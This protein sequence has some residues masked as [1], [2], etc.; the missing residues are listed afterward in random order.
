MNTRQTALALCR[1]AR[2]V[3]GTININ[4][5]YNIYACKNIDYICLHFVEPKIC[6]CAF[7]SLCSD[8]G[9]TEQ[10]CCQKQTFALFLKMYVFYFL[11]PLSQRS[12]TRALKWSRGEPKTHFP[13][14]PALSRVARGTLEAAC[15]VV[16]W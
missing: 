3:L 2:P 7:V 16:R 14:H 11:C 10:T 13:L 1:G 4:M 15:G 8:V 5:F 6:Q 12:D 9:T